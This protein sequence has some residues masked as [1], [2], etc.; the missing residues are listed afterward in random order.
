MR[1]EFSILIGITLFFFV[2]CREETEYIEEKPEEPNEELEG[3]SCV[4]E[5]LLK[6]I[7]EVHKKHGMDVVVDF[8]QHR[9]KYYIDIISAYFPG[10]DG[11]VDGYFYFGKDRVIFRNLDSCS[12]DLLEPCA[13]DTSPLGIIDCPPHEP[14]QDAYVIDPNGEII[15]IKSFNKGG[16]GRLVVNNGIIDTVNYRTPWPKIIPPPPAIPEQGND[17]I[18]DPNEIFEVVEKA[19]EFP[20][21]MQAMYS[22]LGSEIMYPQEAFDQN[23]QGKVYVQFVVEKDGSITDVNVIKGVHIS[24]DMEA[25]R[26]I[27][28]MPKWSSG[29]Q[30]GKKV[31]VRYT[32]PI[33]FTIN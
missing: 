22:Y 14:S 11:S 16:T 19:P 12:L 13:F 8:F 20:G 21:G 3:L 5:E 31:R 15:L 18:K 28:N 32:I 30:K 26:V 4:D 17:K 25:T 1:N 23:I 2:S 6:I 24:L 10:D 33:N 29:K 7:K 9:D 27:S